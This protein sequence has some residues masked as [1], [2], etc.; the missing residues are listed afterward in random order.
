MPNSVG[1]LPS[2]G[3][4]TRLHKPN[5]VNRDLGHPDI[6]RFVDLHGR[7]AIRTDEDMSQQVIVVNHIHA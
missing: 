2:L 3:Q 6:V 7:T 5:S 1:I 4:V